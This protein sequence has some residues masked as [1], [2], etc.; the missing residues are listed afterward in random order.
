MQ[1]RFHP[2]EIAELL[3][4]ARNNTFQLYQSV[5]SEDVLRRS[6]GFG[7]RP[8]LWHLAHIGV[9]ESYWILQRVKGDPTISERYDVIFDPI[10]TPREESK[11]LPSIQ[12]MREYLS[13]VRQEVLSYLEDLEGNEQS[14]LLQGGYIFDLVLE[15]E[16]Q[17][18]ET[19]NYLMRLLDPSAKQAPKDYSVRS[20]FLMWAQESKDRDMVKVEGGPFEMGSNGYLSVP[21]IYDNEQPRHTVHLKDFKI[22]RNLVTNQ[23]FLEF[24]NSGGYSLQSLWSPEG[25]KWKEENGINLPL[26]WRREGDEDSS[27]WQVQEMFETSELNPNLPVTGVS[28]H[29][30]SAYAQFVGKRLPTEAEWEKAASWDP[31]SK[32]RRCFAW[33]DEMPEKHL[34]NFNNNLYGPSPVGAF[35]A[36]KS[37]YGCLDMTGNVWEWASSTFGP[38]P[39]FEA[40]PYPE[41]SEVWFDGDH[42]IL[43]GGS[44]VTRAPLLRTSFRN[45]FRP[46]FRIAFAGFRC[47]TDD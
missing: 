2:D 5:T 18:Q 9:F 24:I 26:F 20:D 46:G 31:I 40:Y 37:A 47:A 33:G 3:N 8:I 12:E 15:H 10:K 22:D 36:G 27:Q 34:A 13:K 35:P 41:Y 38:Y 16:Y 39:G 32:S 14:P 25:W 17:H 43:K 4:K 28:W 19:I 1:K 21:F 29:E 7:F 42:R 44:W 11:D 45:F 6:P 23:D 30:A